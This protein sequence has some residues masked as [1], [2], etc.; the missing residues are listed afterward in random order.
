MARPRIGQER[1]EEI[2]AAF[3][4]CVARKGLAGTTLTDV[5]QEAGQPRSLVRYFIGNRADMVNALID[6]LLLRGEEQFRQWPGHGTPE[7]MHRFVLDRIFADQT[8]NIVIMELWHLALRDDALRARLA[9]IYK[10][11][12]LEV[13]A[14]MADENDPHPEAQD[15]A[16][17][18][19]ALAF[20]TAFFRYLGIAPASP[21]RIRAISRQLLDQH[22]LSAQELET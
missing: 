7:D 12:I 2:L 20:G 4:A 14:M 11:V 18:A 9:A 19:V 10:Q 3:E 1:R 21:D 15:R 16:F 13:A 22:S 8:T 17:S 5:A 6:R